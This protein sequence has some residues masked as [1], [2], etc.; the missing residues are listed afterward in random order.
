MVK[1]T[2]GGK[3]VGAQHRYAMVLHTDQRHPHVHVVVKAESEDG[4]R[5]HIDKEMLPGRSSVPDP[6]DRAILSA[7]RPAPWLGHGLYRFQ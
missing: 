5:L 6:P 7:Y 1:V 2:G 3:R 4:R